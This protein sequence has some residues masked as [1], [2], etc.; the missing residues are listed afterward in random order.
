[1]PDYKIKLKV[2]IMFSFGLIFSITSLSSYF[3]HRYL[4]IPI[5]IAS[6][7]FMIYGTTEVLYYK[8]WKTLGFSIVTIIIFIVSLLA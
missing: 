4:N 5:I 2:I 8:Y 1:M 3:A 6:F 7:L